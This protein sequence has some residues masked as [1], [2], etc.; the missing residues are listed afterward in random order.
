MCMRASGKSVLQGLGRPHDVSRCSSPW[1]GVT[2]MQSGA[3]P[4][5]APAMSPAPEAHEEPLRHFSVCPTLPAPRSS[6][7]TV[8]ACRPASPH[9]ARSRDALRRSSTRLRSR[10]SLL[11]GPYRCRWRTS[12]FGWG[13]PTQARGW[14]DRVARRRLAVLVIFLVQNREDVTV[15][16]LFWEFTWPVWLLTLVA[17][18]AGALVWL[19]LG[20]LRRHGRRK[21][22]RDDRRS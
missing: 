6:E 1:H 19:G 5:I 2:E 11:G 17:A 7:T 21:E 20:V 9:A 15:E 16:F 3:K 14:C 4:A 10:Y 22:R 18:V 8:D 12:P 13:R